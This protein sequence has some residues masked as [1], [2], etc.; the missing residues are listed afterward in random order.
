MADTMS[1]RDETDLAQDAGREATSPLPA[2]HARRGQ[3]WTAPAAKRRGR[4]VARTSRGRCADAAAKP[5]AAH[6]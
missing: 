1:P 3:H 5:A 6:S 2:Y 4:A